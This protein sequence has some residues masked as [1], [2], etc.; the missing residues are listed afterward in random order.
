MGKI[1]IYS[2]CTAL[3]GICFFLNLR[4]LT[5]P[6]PALRTQILALL[7]YLCLITVLA[8]FLDR[9]HLNAL[10]LPALLFSFAAVCTLAC[11]FLRGAGI[12][13]F[14]HLWGQREFL[15]AILLNTS[16]VFLLFRVSLL[17]EQWA[18][19][20]VRL[21]AD[22]HLVGLALILFAVNAFWMGRAREV[23]RLR[24]ENRRLHQERHQEIQN[25]T[26]LKKRAE[27]ALASV[28]ALERTFGLGK[29]G[30][31]AAQGFNRSMETLVYLLDGQQNGEWVRQERKLRFPSCSV[32]LIDERVEAFHQQVLGEKVRFRFVS[33]RSALAQLTHGRGIE[34]EKL[35]VLV[36]YLLDNALFAVK[37]RG[38][39]DSSIFMEFS[40]TPGGVRLRCADSGV[41]FEPLV[42]ARLG[43]PDNTTRRQ[44]KQR[45]GYG[46]P[47]IFKWLCEWDACLAIVE[48]VNHTYTKEVCIQFGGS[49]RYCI[50]TT[51]EREKL[52]GR[53]A[54]RYGRYIQFLHPSDPGNKSGK[55]SG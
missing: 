9:F 2:A 39:R 21:E 29:D 15:W 17:L 12:E 37:S 24:D 52:I 43:L 49:Y 50:Q 30:V 5:R 10:Y 20:G 55:E 7:G 1:V 32:P 45:H 6:Q 28:Q 11:A 23:R 8:F 40:M 16:A 51:P 53:L 41:A 34:P 46:Y 48:S 42:L 36:G 22:L 38:G 35:M 3:Y 13:R 31:E 47:E 44:E 54:K 25:R 14:L 27:D 18:T 33:Q 26:V 19:E 4:Y